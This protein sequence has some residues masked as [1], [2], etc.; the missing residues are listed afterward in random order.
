M[1]EDQILELDRRLDGILDRL[2]RIETKLC[3]RCE[4]RG[5]IIGSLK[6]RVRG[7]ELNQAKVVGAAAL[8]SV[9]AGYILKGLGLK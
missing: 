1:S 2:C 7:L 9:A 8:L 5:Q 4:S 3:E 6:D